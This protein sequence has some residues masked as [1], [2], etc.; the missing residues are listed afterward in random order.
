MS[1]WRMFAAVA[2]WLCAA[3]A[4]IALAVVATGVAG[5]DSITDPAERDAAMG[6]IGFW[7][8]LAAVAAVCGVI[9]WLMTR[10]VF[11]RVE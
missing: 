1:N 6:Y 4:A 9:S 11:G 2:V 10:G 7:S 3:F 8:F 5:L